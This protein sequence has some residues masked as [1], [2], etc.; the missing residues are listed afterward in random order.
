MMQQLTSRPRQ[1]TASTL[2]ALATMALLIMTTGVQADDVYTLNIGDPHRK[3]RQV[4]PLLDGIRDTHTGEIIDP[5]EMATRLSDAAFVLIGE[6]HTNMD[7]HRVQLQVIKALHAAGRSVVIALEMFPYVDQANL[8]QWSAGEFAKQEFVDTA[9]WYSRWGYPW[10][11]YR[12]IFIFARDNG[13]PMWGVNAPRDTIA[14][15]RK[16]GWDNLPDEDK[17][18]L[19]PQINTD[20]DEHMQLFKAYFQ[21]D[22]AIHGPDSLPEAA[23]RNMYEAQVSWDGVMGFNAVR[24]RKANPDAVVVVL[25][26][27]GH[28]AYGLGIARQLAAWDDGRVGLVMP[29]PADLAQVQASYGDY[30]WGVPTP[31]DPI[32]PTLGV[33]TTTKDG[34]L[35]VLDVESTST[36]ERAGVKAGDLIVSLNGQPV[37]ERGAYMRIMASLSWGDRVT[38]STKRDGE[39]ISASAVLRRQVG[40]EDE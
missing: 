33:A 37:T 15:V 12:D 16:Q 25:V 26:G 35:L 9:S 1:F 27:G 6:E 4:T 24:A 3:D 2:L 17:A 28:V 34:G 22:D 5:A 29:V 19:P 38:L 13:L 11:Y 8:D 14:R 32:Y 31:S 21:T 30:L 23:L 36:A 18:Y 40:S 39:M 10:G 20:S 7:F